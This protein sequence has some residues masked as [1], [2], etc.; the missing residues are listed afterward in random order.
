MGDET[1]ALADR[2]A[3]LERSCRRW[4]IGA[5][6]LALA[7]VAVGAVGAA[8]PGDDVRD[9]RGTLT[10]RRFDVVDDE[11]RTVASFGLRPNLN[12]YPQLYMKH[13]NG[14]AAVSM[15][16]GAGFPNLLLFPRE[17]DSRVFAGI[18]PDGGG[19]LK[20]TDK[21]GKEARPR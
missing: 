15:G 14:H 6:C 3:R 1:R 13:R 17:G 11:G 8:R 21:D 2:L 5:A 10:A 7:L 12:D 4:R 20:V 16:V 19:F 9:F 18:G